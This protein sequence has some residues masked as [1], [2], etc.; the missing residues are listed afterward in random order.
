M[1]T[2]KIITAVAFAVA[3]FAAGVLTGHSGT[4]AT[5]TAPVAVVQTIDDVTSFNNGYH[6][7]MQEAQQHGPAYVAQWLTETR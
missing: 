6:E 1:R 5:P 2:V 4:T 7:A 3:A